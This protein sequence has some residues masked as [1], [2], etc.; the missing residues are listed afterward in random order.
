M[1]S[2][3][4]ALKLSIRASIKLLIEK[5]LEHNKLIIFE[6]NNF[7]TN[8]LQISSSEAEFLLSSLISRSRYDSSDKSYPAQKL[9]LKLDENLEFDASVSPQNSKEIIISISKGLY[10]S[11]QDVFLRLMCSMDFFSNDPDHHDKQLWLGCTC[12]WP[13]SSSAYLPSNR[14]LNYN[15]IK[16]NNLFSN[17]D[18]SF[19]FFSGIP[20]D[21]DRL[22][23]ADFFLEVGMCYV[24]LHEEAHYS[25]GHLGWYKEIYGLFSINEGKKS[26][27]RIEINRYERQALEWQADRTAV[28]GT[29]D[30]F[31]Y[32]KYSLQLPDYCSRASTE[33]LLRALLV[34]IATVMFIMQKKAVHGAESNFYP[35]VKTRLFSAFVITIFRGKEL[36]R[37]QKTDLDLDEWTI[38]GSILGACY[39]LGGIPFRLDEDGGINNDTLIFEKKAEENEKKL[40]IGLFDCIEDMWL[41]ASSVLRATQGDIHNVELDNKLFKSYSN[42]FKIPL[43]DIKKAFVYYSEEEEKILKLLDQKLLNELLPFRQQAGTPG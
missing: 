31:F 7:D 23:L 35:S 42:Q 41:F 4:S 43:S 28:R 13:I 10:F 40:Q 22:Y 14:F 18:R 29:I 2:E 17:T 20:F 5:Y 38:I 16:T 12:M 39:D 27:P 25:N 37:N 21:E 11:L 19:A 34:S 30:T 1:L 15:L 8:F 32:R 36:V 6:E 33:W 9:M 3:F 24:L 26:D